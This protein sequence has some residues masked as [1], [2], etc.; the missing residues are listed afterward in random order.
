MA[1]A[2]YENGSSMMCEGMKR[3]P[4]SSRPSF[5]AGAGAA[6]VAGF[7]A[8]SWA[9]VGTVQMIAAATA[10]EPNVRFMM[11]PCDRS[12]WEGRPSRTGS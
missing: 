4:F 3:W 10:I 8:T 11:S 1:K 7:T 2:V 12:G 5:S 6:G 9:N